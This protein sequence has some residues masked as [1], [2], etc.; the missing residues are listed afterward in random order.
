MSTTTAT[1]A[2]TSPASQRLICP[3][4]ILIDTAE[5]QPFSFTGIRSDAAHGNAEYE[6][7]RRSFCLGRHPHSKG[8]YSIYGH[9]GR[10]GVE[11]KSKDDAYSTF[12]GWDGHRERFEKEL[13]NLSAMSAAMVVVEADFS[14]FLKDAPEWGVKT[15]AENRVIL[16][17]SIIAWAQDYKVPFIFAGNR[18]TAEVTTFRFFERYWRKFQQQER[19]S[20]V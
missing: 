19:G 8:D 3:F 2:D 20:D 4:V 11:R 12:L 15:A 10:V 17:R 6:V 13:E 1:T 5:Q 16:H 14:E 7:N 18:R 9:V